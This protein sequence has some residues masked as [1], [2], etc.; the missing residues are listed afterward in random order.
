MIKTVKKVALAGFVAGVALAA[1]YYFITYAPPG[2]GPDVERADGTIASADMRTEEFVTGIQEHQQQVIERT[3]VIREKVR[4]EI[5]ALDPD[6]LASAA[7]AEIELWRGGSGDNTAARSSGVG[8]AG[9]GVFFERGGAVEPHG[10]R[11]D[12]PP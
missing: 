4:A 12:L 5:G 2:G 10:G 8:S 6:G 7:L 3:V 9:G 1:I 11:E